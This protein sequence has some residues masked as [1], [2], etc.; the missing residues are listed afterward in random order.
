MRPFAL[1]QLKD[2]LS[3][4]GQLVPDGF[5]INKIK[6]HCFAVVSEFD[7]SSVHL[8]DSTFHSMRMWMLLQQHVVDWMV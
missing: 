4:D 7:C 5:W 6:S 3:E 1:S 2:L 8:C